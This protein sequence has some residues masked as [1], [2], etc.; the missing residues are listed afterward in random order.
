ME[1]KAR[2]RQRG[3]MR[4][5]SQSLSLSI[6]D[7]SLVLL[8]QPRGKAFLPSVSSILLLLLPFPFP[9]LSQLLFRSPPLLSFAGGFINRPLLP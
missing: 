6:V 2:K 9:L 7:G 3:R 8:T 4:R 1:T 5:K